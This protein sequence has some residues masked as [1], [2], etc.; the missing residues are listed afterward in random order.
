MPKN[1]EEDLIIIQQFECDDELIDQ[2]EVCEFCGLT[3]DHSIDCI[4]LNNN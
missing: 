3:D 4:K 1:K 2:F